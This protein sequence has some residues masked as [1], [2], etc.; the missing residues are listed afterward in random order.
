MVKF[1][2]VSIDAAAVGISIIVLIISAVPALAIRA[3]P[4]QLAHAAIERPE[5]RLVIDRGAGGHP[6]AV[7]LAGDFKIAG[8][9]LQAVSFAVAVAGL[10]VRAR[11]N[12]S[13]PRPRPFL[14]DRLGGAQAWVV[15]I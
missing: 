9:I 10:K 2:L 3:S 1:E 14:I 13:R 7:A 5:R 6:V 8:F 15:E 11:I 12:S 4:T